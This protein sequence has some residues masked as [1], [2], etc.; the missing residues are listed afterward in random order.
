MRKKHTT[1]CLESV[2][3]HSNR[4]VMSDVMTES[5]YTVSSK[6]MKCNQ[7]PK[8]LA[9]EKNTSCAVFRQNNFVFAQPIAKR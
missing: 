7:S 2:L 6:I 4:N 5:I 8:S 3:S 1:V 9:Y